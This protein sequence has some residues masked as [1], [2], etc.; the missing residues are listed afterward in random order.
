MLSDR[1]IFSLFDFIDPHDCFNSVDVA[2]GVCYYLRDR[3]YDGDCL[4]TTCRGDERKTVRRQLNSLDVFIRTKDELDIL[5]NVKNKTSVF[6]EKKVLSQKPFGLRTYASP[7]EEG[8]IVLRY[9]GGKGLFKRDAITTNQKLIDSW[10]VITSC[11]TNEHAGETDKNGRKR[12]LSTLEILKPG[13]ICTETYMVLDTFNTEEEAINFFNYLQTNFVRF[14]IAMVTPTQHLSKQN[15]RYVPYLN[16]REQWDD[17]RI[18][19]FFGIENGDV[20]F[21]ESTIKPM[22]VAP[23]PFQNLNIELHQYIDHAEVKGDVK[24]EQG[25]LNIN[26]YNEK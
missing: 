14:M 11:A 18:Y 4:V 1:K 23:Y 25:D 22:N 17:E 15:F 12:I 6:L 5:A 7:M 24:L 20:N 26:T 19:E 21:I 16:F 9:S 8:D 2:G 10:K 3:D 13:E